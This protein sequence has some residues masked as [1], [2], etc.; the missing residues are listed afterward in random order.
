M[1]EMIETRVPDVSRSQASRLVDQLLELSSGIPEVAD[2]LLQ[3]VDRHTLEI[4]TEDVDG[5]GYA[6]VINTMAPEV[7]SCGAI[8]ALLGMRFSIAD[9]CSLS[10]LSELE[11]GRHVE[12]LIDDGF[13]LELPM[14]DEFRF[15]HVLA[16]EALRKTLSATEQKELHAA[17]FSLFSD[18]HRRAWHGGRSVPIATAASAAEA[19]LASARLSYAE[20]DFPVT[21][22]NI[23]HAERLSRQSVTLDDQVLRLEALERSGIRATDIRALTTRRAI[24][25]GNH[26]AAVAAATSGLPDAET[27]AGDPARVLALESINQDQLSA[28]DRV[29][30]NVHL[31]RQL[32]FVGRIEEAQRL[33]DQAYAEAQSPDEL[34]R[35]WMAAQIPGG[36]GRTK[37]HPKEMPWFD[38]IQSDELRAGIQ[39]AE[40]INAI[41][42]GKSK[43]AY[44]DI[45]DQVA[46]TTE[47][48]L[49]Q[50]AWFA[51]LH[52]ATALTDRGDQDQA[53]A[54]AAESYRVGERA[55]LQMAGGTYETQHFCWKLHEGSHGDL[56]DPAV[57]SIKSDTAGNIVFEAASAAS[58][59]AYAAAT[60]N[61]TLIRSAR[62][63]V[64]DVGERAAAS[65]FDV[66]VIGMLAD[67]I[68][69]QGSPDLIQWA[70]ARLE[71]MH[72]S[73]LLLSSAVA[74]LGPV[75][76][77]SAKLVL[78]QSDKIDLF[79][80]A[81]AVADS[82]ELLLWQVLGRLRLR[83]TITS[84]DSEADRLF[85]EAREL[86]VTPWLARVVNQDGAG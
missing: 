42:A 41:G 25:L 47:R 1:H 18:P 23:D 40:I 6:A 28:S 48:G 14:P 13:L 72:G 66:A 55:G 68:A 26:H 15:L 82:D 64:T 21:S 5:T 46:L 4:D 75:E 74:N 31:S 54:V 16:A 57:A 71:S 22:R 9:L 65:P 84:S 38:Q 29:H 12:A 27:I 33:A 49:P 34:A 85:L 63:T 81:I 45:L 58:L 52:Q 3:R 32:L 73:Y 76:G 30:L 86:A 62:E 43:A 80:T 2:R 11:T 60:K 51:K 37:T 24:E 39:Q 7:R 10:G 78:D 77:V 67:A 61:H 20:G 8:A 69:G 19:L 56:Y 50:L 17:A 36:L 59:Y 70:S 79:R 35:T 83:Q 53:M 44:G